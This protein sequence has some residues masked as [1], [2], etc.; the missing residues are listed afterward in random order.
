MTPHTMLSNKKMKMS[1]SHL[2]MS[3]VFKKVLPQCSA[4]IL[5]DVLPQIKQEASG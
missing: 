1:L 2:F 5:R 4:K 3:C